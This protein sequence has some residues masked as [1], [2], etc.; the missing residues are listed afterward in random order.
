MTGGAREGSGRKRVNIDLEQVEKLCALQ[1]TD[2]ELASYFGVSPRTIERRKAQ[3]TFA[4]AMARGKSKG[5][6][7]LRRRLHE[8][9]AKGNVAAA[10]FLAKNILGYKDYFANELSGPNG[11]PIAIGPAPELGGLDDDE[12]KQLKE[13]LNKGERPNKG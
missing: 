3:P 1:C 9:A 12:L 11:D 2:E 6:L 4:E 7:S 13:L 10:I 5:R 8:L